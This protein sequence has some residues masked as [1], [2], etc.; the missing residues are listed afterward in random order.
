MVRY[1]RQQGVTEIKVEQ[2]CERSEHNEGEGD[3]EDDVDRDDDDNQFGETDGGGRYLIWAFSTHK[4]E[5]IVA[6]NGSTP[7]TVSRESGPSR[8][9]VKLT[10][11]RRYRYLRVNHARTQSHPIASLSVHLDAVSPHRTNDRY[12][13]GKPAKAVITLHEQSFSTTW[14]SGLGIQS[15]NGKR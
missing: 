10:V 6:F 7:H 4:T 1:A 14:T 13:L 11:I 12:V 15:D 2:I 3:V 8:H 5:A 9:H